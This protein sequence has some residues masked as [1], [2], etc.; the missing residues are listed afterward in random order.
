LLGQILGIEGL[1]ASELTS[2]LPQSVLQVAHA[3]GPLLVH[4]GDRPLA[5]MEL[6][7]VEP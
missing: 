5:R 6:T 2:A 3:M 7:T 1:H 4:P